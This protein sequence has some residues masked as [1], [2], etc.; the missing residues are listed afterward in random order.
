MATWWEDGTELVV[1]DLNKP[2]GYTEP[3]TA[4]PLVTDWPEFARPGA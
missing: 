2:K 3:E 4:S 1:A